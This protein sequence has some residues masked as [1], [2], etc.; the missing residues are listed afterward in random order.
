MLRKSIKANSKGEDS[1]SREIYLFH[2]LSIGLLIIFLLL[3]QIF[4][5]LVFA[6]SFACAAYG[7]VGFNYSRTKTFLTGIFFVTKY[8]NIRKTRVASILLL[9]GGVFA[10]LFSFS[11]LTIVLLC[12]AALCYGQVTFQDLSKQMYQLK[13]KKR[14]SQLKR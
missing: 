12:C 10:V 11:T 3:N 13:E 14:D 4:L 6:V 2:I 8:E 5:L 1:R 9:L 7:I